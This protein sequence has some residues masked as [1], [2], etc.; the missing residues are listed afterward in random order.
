M[1]QGKNATLSAAIEKANVADGEL[2]TEVDSSALRIVAGQ[3]Q[4]PRL[5]GEGTYRQIV[6]GPFPRSRSHCDL[7][8]RKARLQDARTTTG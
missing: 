4:D 6:G 7:R 1:A 5:A 8:L 3:E 2:L